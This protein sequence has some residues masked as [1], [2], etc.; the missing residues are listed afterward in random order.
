VA[1]ALQDHDRA[2][3]LGENTFGKG[4]VQ[5]VFPMTENTGLALTT[6]RYYTPSNRLIQRDYQNTSFFD[7]YYRKNL[8]SKNLN[9]VGMTDTGRKV[10]G[11]GG[12][13]PDEKYQA[14]KFTRL[15]G[16]LLRSYAFL[17]FS[18]QYLTR[19]DRSKIA[20]DWTPDPGVI[21]EFK[22]FA[23]KEGLEFNEAEFN[24]N[25]EWIKTQLRKEFLINVFNMEESRKMEVETDP[26]V[27]KA[28][29]QL[30]KAKELLDRARQLLVQ[31]RTRD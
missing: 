20:K 21:Q 2:W 9:D 7:Y 29:E 3:I 4:L 26:M 19:H 10:Y 6:A 13:A 16:Q 5:T 24:D 12:I 28:I 31:R 14:P 18:A 1:G 11:G 27:Q 15:Q 30:P 22:Q 8:E 25:I 17:N 23:L